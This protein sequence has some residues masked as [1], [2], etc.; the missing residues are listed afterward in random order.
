MFLKLIELFKN[1]RNTPRKVVFDRF[2]NHFNPNGITQTA[3]GINISKII[4]HLAIKSFLDE[5]NS[6]KNITIELAGVAGSYS[7]SRFRYGIF[8]L[9]ISHQNVEALIDNKIAYYQ[10]ERMGMDFMD[11]KQG[12]EYLLF[13]SDIDL[14]FKFNTNNKIFFDFTNEISQN[15]FNKYGVFIEG[16]PFIQNDPLHMGKPLLKYTSPLFLENK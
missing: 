13:P 9:N 1:I 16:I 3:L 12:E 7:K 6:N 8:P 5:V 2:S 10:S 14:V 15:V 11:Q 4:Q